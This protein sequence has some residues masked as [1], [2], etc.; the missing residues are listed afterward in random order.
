[1]HRIIIV[2]VRVQNTGAE[3][4]AVIRK[5]KPKILN[6]S[7]KNIFFIEL[8]DKKSYSTD[9]VISCECKEDLGLTCKSYSNAYSCYS[10]YNGKKCHCSNPVSQYWESSISTCGKV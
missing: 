8:V 6:S 7:L 3:L 10:S 5:K 1:M 9:C 2:H 4:I